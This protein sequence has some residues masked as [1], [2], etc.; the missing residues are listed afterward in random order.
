[1]PC[2]IPQAAAK[3]SAALAVRR[4]ATYAA[5]SDI[6]RKSTL[7]APSLGNPGRGRETQKVD[8]F[9]ARLFA[10]NKLRVRNFWAAMTLASA[11]EKTHFPAGN[12]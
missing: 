7:P 1:M 3:Q 4:A 5:S 6:F 8:P 12:G 2:L 10:T 11:A 9:W